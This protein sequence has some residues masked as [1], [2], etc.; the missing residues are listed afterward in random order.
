MKNPKALL[1]RFRTDEAGA[2]LIEYTLLTGIITAA[3]LAVVVALGIWIAL[4]WTTLG[5]A[6]PS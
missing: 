4:R 1:R 2:S 3:V 5:G 6:L